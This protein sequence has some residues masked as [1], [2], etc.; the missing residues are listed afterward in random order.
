MATL[1]AVHEADDGRIDVEVNQ[2]LL[3]LEVELEHEAL[4]RPVGEA[5][6][7]GQD[8]VGPLQRGLGG[9]VVREDA[10]PERVG[11]RDG[12]APHH[13]RDDGSAEPARQRGEL[14]GSPGGDDAAAGHDERPLRLAQ[15]P[16]GIVDQPRV[17]RGRPVAERLAPAL[18]L[19]HEQIGRQRERDG[20]LAPRAEE[21]EGALDGGGDLPRVVDRLGPGSRRA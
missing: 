7:D 18:G 9:P 20:P 11:L 1:R 16:G 19:R 3:G 15:A 4:G 17:A 12:A 10:K 21:M 14:G 5:A 13:R 6:A 2:R 8:D